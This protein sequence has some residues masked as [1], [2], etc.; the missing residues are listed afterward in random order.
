MSLVSKLL[1]FQQVVLS[2]TGHCRSYATT[3][4]STLSSRC[5]SQICTFKIVKMCTTS[6]TISFS[7]FGSQNCFFVC[8]I[9]RHDYLA[10]IECVGL[11]SLSQNVKRKFEGRVVELVFENN[12]I[13]EALRA[14]SGGIWKD[15]IPA[16]S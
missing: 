8:Q 14:S 16:P 11:I 12:Q 6:E 4:C 7:I 13:A 1:I 2:S 9:Y 3:R 10:R 15:Y 5:C